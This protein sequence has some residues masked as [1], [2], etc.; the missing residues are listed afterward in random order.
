MPPVPVRWSAWLGRG[1]SNRRLPSSRP[2]HFA[3]FLA[4]VPHIHVLT[5][6]PRVQGTGCVRRLAVTDGKLRRITVPDP[7]ARSTKTSRTLKS[8]CALANACSTLLALGR[9]AQLHSA[10]GR[11]N[12]AIF[13]TVVYGGLTDSSSAT[14]AGK[15]RPNTIKSPQSGLCSL[16]RVVRR[17]TL[18]SPLTALKTADDCFDSDETQQSKAEGAATWG[19]KRRWVQ[20]GWRVQ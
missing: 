14:G 3:V 10:N 20:T 7:S 1:A 8:G 5:G 18:N 12:S 15:S 9:S 11:Q 19:Q 16:E 2:T 13:F 6:V 17:W 4:V